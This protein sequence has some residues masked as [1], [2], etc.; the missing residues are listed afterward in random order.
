[1]DKQ[2]Y[3]KRFDAR[4]RAGK[5]AA[6]TVS[7]FDLMDMIPD[8]EAAIAYLTPILWPDGPV[9]PYCGSHDNYIRKGKANMHWCKECRK[10]FTIRVGTIFHRS[11]VPLHKW[12]HAMYIIVTA[13][14]GISSLQLSKQIGVTQKSAWFLEQRI[15]AACGNQTA[16]ILSGI[17]EVDETYI[18]GIEKNKH[19]KKR[20]HPKGGPKGKAAVM[21]MRDRSGQVAAKV[22]E[23]ADK[24]TLQ[25]EVRGAAAPGSTVCTDEHTAY[26]GLGDFCDHR[27][28]CHSAKQ[29]VDG[30]ASTNGVESLWAVL[31]RAFY[32]TFHSISEK[33]LQFYVDEV[34]FRMNEG[35]CSI[36]T[37]DRL[38]SLVK[39]MMHRRLTYKALTEGEY[40]KAA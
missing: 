27:T 7:T 28:V 29:Y 37:V 4:F 11:H 17:I 39:G 34:V 20:L 26:A 3:D 12:L 16:K 1:M 2:Q 33:H 13:R 22:V 21:G 35:N 24:P 18:G 19:S 5:P 30:M 40:G 31:K 15:R 6:A 32:G 38:E 25:G 23:R 10:D 14:K 9:C 36:D 8:E